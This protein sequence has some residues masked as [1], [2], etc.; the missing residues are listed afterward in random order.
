MLPAAQNAKLPKWDRASC[1]A[2]KAAI[3]L[4]ATIALKALLACKARINRFS[5]LSALNR[6][7]LVG[8]TRT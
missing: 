3:A 1:T 2:L 6:T 4:K 7:F 8:A 5:G